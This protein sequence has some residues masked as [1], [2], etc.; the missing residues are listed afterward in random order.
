MQRIN[1]ASATGE[2]SGLTTEQ[3]VAESRRYGNHL[4]VEFG[5]WY[6]SSAVVADGTTPDRAEDAYS[7]YLPAATPGCRAPHVWLGQDNDQLSVLDLCGPSFTLLVGPDGAEW[8]REVDQTRQALGLPIACYRIGSAG[9][10][11]DGSFGEAYGIESEGA[12]LV[13]PDA[14]IAWRA[15]SRADE[16][17]SITSALEQILQRE[18]AQ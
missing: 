17:P 18:A 1:V 8:E 3:I 15:K 14:H 5:S 12:V 2:E 6:Q 13:R 16:V 7:D 11:D 10:Q 4:G 9:L